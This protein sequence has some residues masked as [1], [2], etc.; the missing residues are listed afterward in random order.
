MTANLGYPA[1]VALRILHLLGHRCGVHLVATHLVP[2][3]QQSRVT[4]T[5]FHNI[6][7]VPTVGVL[8]VKDIV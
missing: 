1:P 8:Q 7:I 2:A 6:S 5:L 3:R 4:Q